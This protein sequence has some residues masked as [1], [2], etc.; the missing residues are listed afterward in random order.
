VN[1][2]PP[3]GRIFSR[4]CVLWLPRIG[5][6]FLSLVLS[7]TGGAVC[8]GAEPL[9][10]KL[11]PEAVIER[12]PIAKG[13]ALLALPVELKRKK[14]LFALDTGAASCV[15]DSSLIPL[16]GE[17]IQTRTVATSDGTARTQLFQPPDAKLGGLNL[18]AGRPVVA[19]DLCRMREGTGQDVYGL[20]GMD[21]LAKHVVRID[22]DLGEVVFLKSAGVE[23]RRRLPMTIE[24]NLPYA[25]VKI[26][27]M[28]EPRPFLIDTGCSPGGGTG[29]MRVETFDALTK[30]G[31]IKPIGNA[32]AQSLS[33]MTLRRRG[34]VKEISL[35]DH[36][37]A[38]LIFSASLRNILGMNYWARYVTTFDFPGG[39]IY[40]KRGSS[41]D[42]PDMHDMSGLTLVRAEGRTLVISVEEGSPSALAG[43]SPQD[44][45]LKANG[46]AAEGLPLQALRLLLAE[47]GAK[48]ALLL[49]RGGD[50][51]NVSLALPK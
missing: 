26:S 45:I 34:M 49:S 30:Q 47:K 41:Y 9:D 46:K 5:A 35:A 24:N 13:E 12:F 20:I 8:A 38:N 25:Q 1:P 44:A 31:M 42:Q 48:V 36:H 6:L 2:S 33:G 11:P 22:P 43:I 10:E 23:P 27:G 39:A 28:D 21:F 40:L 16:L 3:I 51:R 17:P 18:R 4:D 37:H 14:F 32:E 15:Y 19:A 7:L 50:K 29:L